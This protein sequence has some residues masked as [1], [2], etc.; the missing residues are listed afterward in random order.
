M[1]LGRVRTES[2]DDPRLREPRGNLTARQKSAEGIVA[3][4]MVPVTKARTEGAASR[5][6]VS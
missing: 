4:G 2:I 5:P 3:T 6:T 1:R